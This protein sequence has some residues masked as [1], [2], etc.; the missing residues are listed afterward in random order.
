ML[1][2]AFLFVYLAAMIGIG[3]LYSKN[4][5]TS[6]DYL[7]GG[8]TL[9][10]NLIGISNISLNVSAATFIGY[11]GMGFTLGLSGAWVYFLMAV[12]IFTWARW[13]APRVRSK[14]KFN[15]LP[16]YLE[17][18]FGGKWARRM[19]SILVMGREIAWVASGLSGFGLLGDLLLGVP[20]WMGALFGLGVTVIYVIMGGY[21]AATITNFYQ[22]LLIFGGSFFILVASISKMGGFAAAFSKGLTNFPNMFS[23]TNNSMVTLIGW[24]LTQSFFYWTVQSVVIKTSLSAAN[25]KIAMKGSGISG[26][27]QSCWYFLPFMLGMAARAALGDATTANS[28]YVDLIMWVCGPVFGSFMMVPFAAA[29]MATADHALLSAS[30]NI[31]EDWYAPFKKNLTDK[32]KVKISRISVFCL[33]VFAYTVA[34]AFP[35]ILE[36]CLLAVKFGAI[37]APA[38]IGSIFWKRSRGCVKTYVTMMVTCSIT[39]VFLLYQQMKTVQMAGSAFIYSMD[40]IIPVLPL[41]FII[42]I[43]GVLIE[44]SSENKTILIAKSQ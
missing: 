33:A 43:G 2:I 26:A 18:H 27:F 13:G 41:A 34:L 28:S 21:L 38:M 6:D 17:S 35:F 25:P 32:Q 22:T 31:V 9:G 36:L 42:F 8:N 11:G 15:T 30:G 23:A 14:G 20:Y 12:G 37:L 4:Q 24:L 19:A 16:A 5:N 3:A 1:A 44:G 40:P 7:A 39:L 29:I 10:P